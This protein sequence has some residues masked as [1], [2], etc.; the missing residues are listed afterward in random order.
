MP[1]QPSAAPGTSADVVAAAV[2]RG[3]GALDE[4]QAKALLAD[5]GVA[6][7]QGGLARDEDEAVAIARQLDG[8][9]VVKALGADITR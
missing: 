5:Y 7:P 2:A 8:P 1:T 3:D 9:V 4:S 6:V